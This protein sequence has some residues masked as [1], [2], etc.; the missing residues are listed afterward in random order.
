[1]RNRILA[2]ALTVLMMVTM[3]P[4]V[5]A[6]E[7]VPCLTVD[8]SLVIIGDSNTVYLKKLNPDI[9]AAR[10]YARVNATIAECA[11]NYSSYHAD[12]YDYGIYQL[13]SALDGS[14]FHTVII[15]IGTNNAGTPGS[16]YKE[17]YADLLTMLYGKNP[18]AVIYLC[19]ILPI[20]PN[21]YSGPY[22]DVF[23]VANINRINACVVEVQQEFVGKGY[24]ARIMDLNTPFQNA[25]GVLN[26][27][28]DNGGGIHL[29]VSGYYYLNEVVQTTLAKGDPK[30]NH[31]WGEASVQTAPTCGSDG[32][33]IYTCTVCGAEKTASI[34]ATGNHNWD[35]GTVLEAATCVRDGLRRLSCRVCGAKKDE[36]IPA[37]GVH[38]WDSGTVIEA[39]TCAKAGLLRRSCQVCE[40]TKDEVIPVSPTH[41]W[42]QGTVVTQATCAESGVLHRTCQVCGIGTDET[43]PA[44]GI[45]SWDSGTITKMPD[46]VKTGTC[47]WTCLVC[48]KETSASI[49]ALGHRWSLTA[50]LTEGETLHESTG[51]YTCSRCQQTKEACLCAAEVFTDLPA[52]EHWSHNAIDWAY[53]NGLTSG[54]TPTTFS[55]KKVV[56]RGQVVTFLHAFRGKPETGVSNPFQDVPE[57]AYYYTPVLWAV[58]NEITGG[59]SETTFS[60]GKPCTRAQIVT[61][62][63]AA[64]GRPE[65]EQTECRFEDLNESKY[66][67]K[68]VLWAAENGITTGLNDTHFGPSHSCTRAQM[69]TFLKA[70]APLLTVE[71]ED[72]EEPGE[73]EDPEEPGEPEDPEEPGEPEDPEEPGEPENPEE[74]GEPENPEE[75]GEPENPEEPGEP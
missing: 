64:A 17:Y 34:P 39:A 45:H 72:P 12:G 67:Y 75:P 65:P 13:I 38:S 71:P 52:A 5:S 28:Y 57:T 58:E 69:V 11:R 9:Q 43:I 47:R 1:M 59:S 73:P 54:T 6:S 19:K 31:S 10:I 61:F 32:E 62:L 18:N 74:P 24:D 46:C 4:T 41:S 35:G 49:P 60:P 40:A 51:L 27:S 66:Y 70:A 25:Y 2:L 44:T 21:N 15:N 53:F 63:W 50:Q 33:G 56:T 23:T 55:P 29:S 37:T 8:Q 48:G 30:A 22:P 14:S 3:L 16:T 20:N 26:P 42:N 7:T 36:V 68:A